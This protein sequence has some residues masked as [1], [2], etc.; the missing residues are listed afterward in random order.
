[1][2]IGFDGSRAF[3]SSRTGTENYS[4]Q[5]L[6]HLSE[7]DQTNHYYVYLRPGTTPGNWPD[8]FHFKTLPYPR[9]WTQI[10]LALQTFKDPLDVLFVPSHTLPLVRKPGLKTVLTVHDLGAEY[11]P[12]M[13]QFKQRLYLGLMTRFQ[14]RSATRL[15]AVSKAT[16][17]DLTTRIGIPSRKIS[18][19]YEGFND[20]L[21][22]TKDHYDGLKSKY[23][24]FV[25]TI[26]PRKNLYRLIQAYR[27]ANI[28]HDLV[29]AGSRGWMSDPIF[30]LGNETPGVHFLGY[31]PDSDLPKL[32]SG[33][34]AFVF[35]SLFE[36]F[37][38]PVL[39]AFA[40]DCPVLTSNSSSLP[41][42][43]GDA[44]IMVDP[45]SVED[46]KRGLQKVVDPATRQALIKKG[47]VQLKKFSWTRAA[48]E[49]LALLKSV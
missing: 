21:R 5:L 36:G 10:G 13:H 20:T 7:I 4:Y 6:K 27:N 22:H 25:G 19:I 12:A 41:E 1:M 24:L 47:R 15:I 42:V 39:E 44:A 43:A 28:G 18:V 23:L 16:K 26:Q 2:N 9:L 8:N 3:N 33:A 48:E 29:L 32:Y 31:V 17:Q 46:I 14:L 45:Y 30:Q 38:L 49:T 35:P 40:C 34:T 11:L 37:G